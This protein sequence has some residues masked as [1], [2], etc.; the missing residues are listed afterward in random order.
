VPVLG[1]LLDATAPKADQRELGRDEEGVQR[2]ENG[3]G[4]Q[5]YRDV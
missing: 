5:A 2:D 4:C 3:D 1:H